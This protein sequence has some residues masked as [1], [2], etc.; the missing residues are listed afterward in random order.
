MSK[1]SR[2]LEVSVK[3]LQIET[4]K[5]RIRGTSDLI[6]HA[7]S[8]KARK[9]MEEAQQG[10]SRTKKPPRVPD[11]EREAAL[12]KMP[13]GRPAFPSRGFKTAIVDA[14]RLLDILPMVTAKVSLH[15]L[16]DMVPI[17][18]ERYDRT[19][20]VRLEGGTA[21]IAYRPAFRGWS[22]TLPITFVVN[23]LTAEQVV[24][25]VNAGG[26]CGVGEWRPS[27]PKGKSGTF[28]MFEVVT[29]E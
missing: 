6:M 7:W 8:E 9:Q 27:C 28:G 11:E 13:D 2:P 18:G 3:P 26:L 24:N 15:V 21:S 20:H 4:I 14:C 12:Y 16:G 10:K 5:V 19:D 29:D 23:V 25:L 22:A 1:P 17:E